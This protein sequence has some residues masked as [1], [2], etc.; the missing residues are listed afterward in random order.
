[1][2]DAQSGEVLALANYPSFTPADRRNLNGGQLR[3]RALTDTFEPGSTMK[4]FIAAWAMESG[5]VTP[6]TVIQTAPGS[7][8]ITG[9]TSLKLTEVNE[10]RFRG[11]RHCA[12][13]IGMG[14]S[15]VL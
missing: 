2:L 8:N 4:P 15:E 10:A 12:C 6:N 14:L 11:C 5:R 13:E 1:M 3:N 7:I 9:S